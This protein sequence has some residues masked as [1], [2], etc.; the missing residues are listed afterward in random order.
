MTAEARVCRQR[1]FVFA[2]GEEGHVA[3]TGVVNAGDTSDLD[4]AVAIETA[5]EA[6]GQL[7]ELHSANLTGSML[8]RAC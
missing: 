7:S 5:V 1:L 8:T 2:V 3:R 6:S 4:V